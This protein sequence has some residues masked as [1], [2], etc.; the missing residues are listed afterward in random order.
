MLTKSKINFSDILMQIIMTLFPL[1]F[2]FYF[3]L[4]FINMKNFQK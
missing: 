2:L 4:I 1:Y 3:Y